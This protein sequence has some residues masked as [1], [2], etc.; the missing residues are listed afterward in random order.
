MTSENNTLEQ[1]IAGCVLGAATGSIFGRYVEH[2]AWR[3]SM[4]ERIAAAATFPA[5]AAG[6]GWGEHGID[7]NAQM[8]AVCRAVIEYG[9]RPTVEDLAGVWLRNAEPL[10]FGDGEITIKPR[11]NPIRYALRNTYELL[12]AGTPPRIVGSLNVPMTTGIY[13]VPAAA[14][15]NACDP[16]QAYLDGVSLASLFQR[17]RGTVVPGILAAMA[18]EAMRPGATA[19]S[20][21]DVAERTARSVS[22]L[23]PGREPVETAAFLV[24][25][26]R[27]AG[28]HATSSA[29]VYVRTRHLVSRYN[30]RDPWK[31]LALAVACFA[32][33]GDDL[34][35]A[36][37]TGAL[38][39]QSP[40][41]LGGCC[42]L[43]CGALHGS[44]AL[45][46]SWL[47]LLDGLRG[48]AEL[49]GAATDLA[50][51][52]LDGA[53]RRLARARNLLFEVRAMTPDEVD[54]VCE[55]DREAFLNSRYGEM[56]ARRTLSADELRT[57]QSVKDFRTYCIE[58]PDRVLVAVD[59]GEIAGF[60]TFDVNDE[61]QSGK[62]V[63]CA[64]LPAYRGRGIG[65]A[66]VRRVLR[67]L[68]SRGVRLARVTTSHVPE[69]CRMYEKA[70]FR[71]VLRRLDH[72]KHG[73]PFYTSKYELEL[74]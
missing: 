14:A 53:R 26:A 28:R 58:H 59:G 31:T 37:K 56:T 18:A 27:R 49:R 4:A 35:R 63:N 48:A 44:G 64:V 68:R 66:L 46:Q 32:F 25:E 2:R 38:D 13:A 40:D 60:A 69:A 45:P 50:A 74:E 6:L 71:L 57:W 55:V 3:R 72:D 23:L 73:E 41:F 52:A 21:L 20:V 22:R 5:D 1:R 34:E 54:R 39:E 67:E 65:V 43:L 70:G 8:L 19:A 61:E 10:A 29:D 15:V 24:T 7:F 42:G 30:R 9:G 11:A 62:V 17:D 51:Q 33:T 16:E 12:T 36:V 47:D